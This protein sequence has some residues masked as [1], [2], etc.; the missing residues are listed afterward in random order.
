MTLFHT[1][2]GMTASNNL[3]TSSEPPS[4]LLQ[5][6]RLDEADS[7]W[8]VRHN[9]SYIKSEHPDRVGSY[10]YGMDRRGSFMLC[11]MA[12]PLEELNKD[13]ERFGLDE[14]ILGY[15]VYDENDQLIALD[16]FKNDA[17]LSLVVAST[18]AIVGLLM[19]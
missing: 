9:F 5:S 6:L 4:T 11:A 18:L 16:D 2:S 19:F 12:S 13:G 17:G 7:P 3:V 8:I 14:F 10:T 15:K 1:Y